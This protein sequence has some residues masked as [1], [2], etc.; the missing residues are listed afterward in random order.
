MDLN[1]IKKLVKQSDTKIVML[2]L[3]GIGGLPRESDNKTELEASYTPNFDELAS[4]SVCG[5]HVPV[6]PGITPGS[7]PGH[8][9][10][11]G[12]DP[13]KYQV[14]RGVLAALGIGFDLKNNDVAARGNF[15]TIDERGKVIDRRAGRISTEKNDELCELLGKIEIPGVEIHVKTVKEHRFLLVL[16]GEGLSGSLYDTDPQEIGVAPIEPKGF[17]AKE[18]R[19]V[20]IVKDF[21]EQAKKLLANS[22][23]ANMILLRGF[24]QKPDWP[25]Y[26]DAFGIKSAAIA[27]YPMYRGLARLLGMKL[28]ETGTTIQEEIATLEKNWNDFDFFFIHIKPTDSSGEDGDFERK[29][30]VIEEVDK[31]IPRIIALKPDVIFI[32]GDHSTPAK[33]KK[34]SWHPV[35]TI[36]WSELCRPDNVKSFGERACI[37][38]G[39]GPRIP[40]VDLIPIALANAQRLEKFGA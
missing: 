17:T 12:Y 33:M 3:D 23:P 31:E 4:R 35:P 38:G 18:D 11:F 7:G 27:A 10:V 22:H 16:R 32:T 5:L 1:F 26:E 37:S 36:I 9:G 34:H 6:G 20:V 2:I 19:T 30:R 29:V 28:L 13:L 24:S 21:L 15:C 40:A 8:L 14:G 39:L 25:S